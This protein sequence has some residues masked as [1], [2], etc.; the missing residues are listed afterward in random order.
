[1]RAT[2]TAAETDFVDKETEAMCSFYAQNN[3][4]HYC[5]TAHFCVKSQVHIWVCRINLLFIVSSRRI[6]ARKDPKISSAFFWE[7]IH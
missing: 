6:R 2:L 7:S 4:Q 5:E 1:M 3:C